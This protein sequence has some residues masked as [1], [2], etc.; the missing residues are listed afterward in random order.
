[1]PT[2]LLSVACDIDLTFTTGGDADWFLQT[3]E[4]YYDN[5][6]AQSGEID[7]DESTWLQTTVEGRG[8]ISFWWKT[9][10]DESDEVIFY[11]DGSWKGER[12]GT[13]DWRQ[14]TKSITTT[15]THTLRWLYR[16]D[17]SGSVGS[18]CAW[19]DCVVWTGTMPDANDWN[20]IEYVYDLSGRRIEKKVDGTTELKFL[21]DGDQIIAEYDA[22]DTLL[23]KYVHG[24]GIDEPICLIESSGTY[25]GTQ[26]YHYDALGNVVALT[27]ASGDVVQLYEYSVYGQVA[28][29]DPNHPNRFM[30]TG[31]EF[32]K[33]TGLYYYRARYYH[34]EIG[35][36]LQTD[37]IGYGDGMNWYAY[38]QNGPIGR[39][40]P[41]GCV[42]KQNVDKDAFW[43]TF[44]FTFSAE[45]IADAG[46]VTA[47]NVTELTG[48]F[49]NVSFKLWS[50]CPNWLIGDTS[51]S[52]DGSEITVKFHSTWYWWEQEAPRK[53][54]MSVFTAR[55]KADQQDR[56]SPVV[57]KVPMI[58]IDG[59]ALLTQRAFR[60]IMTP[61]INEINGW[62]NE[63][64][65]TLQ[66]IV[67]PFRNVVD[68]GW[69]WFGCV[70]ELAG[71]AACP[72]QCGGGSFAGFGH[73]TQPFASCDGGGCPV[74][75][76]WTWPAA[77]NHPG[78][79][80]PSP[81]WARRVC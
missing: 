21:Y 38:C 57:A 66:S 68:G 15:G 2:S 26:Y 81:S 50:L 64:V 59:K 65:A 76:R 29:S 61:Q 37:P 74:R 9:S 35:R 16:K 41:S 18:D 6:A 67:T 28:A 52:A 40:D 70:R 25:A 55:V 20:E 3:E 11:I 12:D 5:D 73:D 77:A 27:D 24:P 58:T 72:G 79:L 34:P 54:A 48:R 45:C 13:G 63:T 47:L 51:L 46:D 39:T 56:G 32:D 7:D 4:Y 49:F 53:P 14:V 71:H 33:D 31:R 42:A 19:V 60:K 80:G 1:V 36:F 44:T 75:R 23:R 62:N 17:A 22:N 30:F 8:N 43:W 78:T 10:C 69:P